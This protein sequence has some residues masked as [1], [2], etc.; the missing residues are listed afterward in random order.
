MTRKLKYTLLITSYLAMMLGFS[1]PAVAI[2]E[3]EC[4]VISAYAS[5]VYEITK[6]QGASRATVTAIFHKNLEDPTMDKDEIYLMLEV[7]PVVYASNSSNDAYNRMLN[8]GCR[9][10]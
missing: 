5:K 9:G 4:G 10:F 8:S 6:G 7:L 1:Q 2:S 3:L